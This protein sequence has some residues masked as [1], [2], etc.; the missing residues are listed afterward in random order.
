MTLAS[1]IGQ[2]WISPT[3]LVSEKVT[4]KSFFNVAP[5]PKLAF[6]LITMSIPFDWVSMA[7]AKNVADVAPAASNNPF[8]ISAGNPDAGVSPGL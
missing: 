8:K 1:N 4:E 7:F 3:L 2:A 6:W 5:L